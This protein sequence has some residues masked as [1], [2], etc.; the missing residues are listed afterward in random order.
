MS[1]VEDEMQVRKRN[2]LYENIAFDKI[3]NRVKILG[4]EN[5]LM[6]INYSGLIMKVIDQLYD[7]IPTSNI[8]ELTAIQCASMC[9]THYDYCSCSRSYST[10]VS[11]YCSQPS[12]SRKRSSPSRSA[13]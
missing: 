6:N 8:D 10:V 13:E 5:N 11:L 3:L 2:G 7:K 12:L 9:T 4:K 1:E